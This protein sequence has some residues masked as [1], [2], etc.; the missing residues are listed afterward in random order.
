[1]TGAMSRILMAWELGAHFGHLAQ[2]AAI[3]MPLRAA[4]HRLLFAARDL[5]GAAEV[6]GPLHLEFVQAPV[7]LRHRRVPAP[8]ANHAEMLAFEGYADP[9]S[10]RGLIAGWVNLA[11]TFGANVIVADYAPGALV[12]GRILG[13]PSVQ[14]GSGF[15][16]PPL[17][18]PMPS[19]RPWE[20]IPRTRLARSEHHVTEVMNRVLRSHHGPE[21][22]CLADLFRSE[23]RLLATFPELD[24]FGLRAGEEY[25]GP[26]YGQS[27]GER[28]RWPAS[29]A[30][31]IFAYL[32]GDVP[33]AGKIVQA[34]ALA[35][36]STICVFP[37]LKTALARTC[38]SDR[39]C[40][41]T[42]AVE[43]APVLAEAGLV[44]TYGGHGLL[45][46]ALAG[47]IPLLI[48][49]H[50]V[51]QYLHAR[52]AEAVGVAALIGGDRSLPVVSRGIAR[53]LSDP[54]PGNAA[55]EF[56]ARHAGFHPDKAV[57]T[58][59]ARIRSV[60]G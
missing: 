15:S 3:A 59:A 58:A 46:A 26:I 12:A 44:L 22:S 49:P 50:T 27:H 36:A 37:G 17:A 35:D 19:I 48:A 34:L 40:I 21:L 5:P 55:R 52:R 30:R 11:R 8:P 51:E 24:P 32:R 42:H 10:A 53:A 56:A 38:S 45:C 25:V 6:L 1:M 28:P 31:R 43:L 54:A 9:S 23:A 47:G 18:S 29:A 39:L 33:G 41:A 20:D 16:I 14:V 57:A 2:L 60:I 7:L 4:G 13:V